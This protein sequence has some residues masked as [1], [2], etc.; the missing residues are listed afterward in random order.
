M[1]LR[2]KAFVLGLLM[3][4]FATSAHAQGSPYNLLGFGEPLFTRLAHLEGI[5][6]GGT[7]LSDG[8]VVNDLNPAAWSWLSRAR[9]ETS[10]RFERVSSELNAA[11]AVGND[12]RFSG[13]SFGSPI[14]NDHKA[15]IALGFAPLTNSSHE[16]RDTSASASKS[17]VSEG[18]VSLAFIGGSIMPTPGIALGSKLDVL[19]GNVRRLGESSFEGDNA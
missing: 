9:L 1:R 19:F 13:L 10:F 15:S 17:Y 8:R 3:V 5:G 18:G 12:F 7:G 4:A 14:W 6:G 11:S 2:S 16:I